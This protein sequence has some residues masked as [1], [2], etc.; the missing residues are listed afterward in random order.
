MRLVPQHR[1][2]ERGIIGLMEPGQRGQRQG[3]FTIAV[4]VVNR[5]PNFGRPIEIANVSPRACNHR[6]SDH[7]LGNVSRI[8]LRYQRHAGAGDSGLLK[9][10]PAQRIGRH[11]VFGNQQEFLVIDP[12][13]RDPA[14]GLAVEHVGRIKPP[15]KANLD[16]AGVGWNAV[17]SEE[18][19][20]GSNFEKAG[21]EVF[22]LIQH[23]L[24]QVRQQI[25]LD[26]FSGHAN[27]LVIAHQ[28]RL[29]RGMN[30]QA[31]R[32]QHRP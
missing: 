22:A 2:R 21:G 29:G 4:A 3:Q 26:Q 13:G 14:G 27:A 16:N 28:M 32:L 20:G 15:A 18:I 31:L 23:F 11:T 7:C 10:N 5:L 9:G 6:L 25:I 17:K 12:Q 8:G 19:G 1:H 30:G 24:E